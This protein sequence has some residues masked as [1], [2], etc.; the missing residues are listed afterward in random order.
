LSGHIFWHTRY[1]LLYYCGWSCCINV[2]LKVCL[3]TALWRNNCS[4][5]PP[6]STK[7][8]C[9]FHSC[10]RFSAD[11]QLLWQSSDP[12]KLFRYAAT[13]YKYVLFS[14]LYKI[15]PIQVCLL[16]TTKDLRKTGLNCNRPEVRQ[17]VRNLSA[18]ERLTRRAL[19]QRRFSS[20]KRR[21]VRVV[22]KR[23]F[24]PFSNLRFVVT[25]FVSFCV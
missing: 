11:L 18:K 23:R 14:L 20:S 8:Y 21:V 5:L 12:V 2:S 6:Q 4:V 3:D 16:K 24:F 19:A 22:V 9:Y 7:K 10:I 1:L 15:Y 25:L 13:N 17:S